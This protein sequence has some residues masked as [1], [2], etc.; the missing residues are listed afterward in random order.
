MKTR[1]LSLAALVCIVVVPAAAARAAVSTTGSVSDTGSYYV[2][3]SASSTGTLRIDGSSVLSRSEGYVGWGSGSTG[4][5]TVTGV[6]SAWASSG[7]L[8]VGMSGNGTLN[9]E[10]GGQVSNVQGFLG[11]NSGSTATGTATVTGS[12]SRWTNSATLWV[13]SNGEGTLTIQGGGQV[14]NANGY[15]ASR[16]GVA[17][18][19]TVTGTGSTWTNAGSLTVGN[20]GIGT[21]DVEAEGQVS[22]TSQSFVGRYVGAVGA[23]TVTGTGSRWTNANDLFI[24]YEGN[25]SLTIERGGQVANLRGHLG[26]QCTAGTVGVDGAGTVTVDGVGS[27]WTCNSD[28]S[29][30]WATNGRGT[31]IIRNGGQATSTEGSIAHGGGTTG[32]VAVTGSGSTWTTSSSLQVGALG[33][34]RLTIEAGGRVND[35]SGLIGFGNASR[36]AVTVTGPGSTWANSRSISVGKTN[37]SSYLG[38]GTLTV[39]DAGLVTADNMTVYPSSSARLHVSGNDMIVLGDSSLTGSVNN[40]G[41]IGFY[42]DAFLA[43]VAYKPITE[44]QNRTMAWTGS[45]SYKAFGGTWNAT[46]KTFTPTALT[47]LTSGETDSISTGERMLFTDP[48]SGKRAGA[49]FGDVTGSPT[50]SATPMGSAALA[51]LA[52]MPGFD[53]WVRSAWNFNTTYAGSDEVLLSFDIGFGKHDLAVWHYDAGA[54]TPYTPDLMT[55]DSHGILSFTV[56][57]FS[58]YAV[59]AVPEPATLSLVALG[60]LAAIFRRRRRA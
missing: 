23:A 27:T 36:G 52:L 33:N 47:L 42:A 24:G 7:Y 6:G 48:A 12:G 17:A 29:L 40:S 50:F 55:Y 25:G 9:I 37:I 1:I 28:I 22:S 44:S 49:S 45:G 56:T 5:A 15:L 41:K 18:A 43:A 54:W 16:A 31:L 58:G 11:S 14:S 8:H 46:N 53:G 26:S 2:G 32:I 59:T 19:A 4:T 60:G 38:L 21:L 30:G 35:T 34:G 57:D 51:A 10:S 20:Y 39:T 13:G 3:Y